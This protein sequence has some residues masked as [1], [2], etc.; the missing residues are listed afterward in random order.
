MDRADLC[1]HAWGTVIPPP[2]ASA[3]KGGARF[4]LVVGPL[5]ATYLSGA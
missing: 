3:A 1:V 2:N 5:G 4:L